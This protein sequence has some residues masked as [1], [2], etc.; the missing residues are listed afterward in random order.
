MISRRLGCRDMSFRLGSILNA[1]IFDA[2][3]FFFRNS[4]FF[5][6]VIFSPGLTLVSL[7]SLFTT[8]VQMEHSAKFNHVTNDIALDAKLAGNFACNGNLIFPHQRIRF[9]LQLTGKILNTCKCTLS[10]FSKNIK[11]Q[12]KSSYLRCNLYTVFRQ[13]LTHF[14]TIL[15][16]FKIQI[17]FDELCQNPQFLVKIIFG[18]TLIL[19]SSN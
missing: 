14:P 15:E 17:F 13:R 9:N 19:E 1:H 12:Q 2:D 4:N 11:T 8:C 16:I 10:H 5:W 7:A 3:L 18:V 6:S